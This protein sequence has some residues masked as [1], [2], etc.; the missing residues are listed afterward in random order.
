MGLG[1]QWA[2]GG[3]TVNHL[4]SHCQ[5]GPA[6]RPLQQALQ[7]WHEVLGSNETV[8]SGN[9]KRWHQGLWQIYGLLVTTQVAQASH[10]LKDLLTVGTDLQAS[11]RGASLSPK[12]RVREGLYTWLLLA[13]VSSR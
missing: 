12:R 3:G 2:G 7:L 5:P 4:H 8:L 6:E 9:Q 1:E 10:E 13:S 11:T